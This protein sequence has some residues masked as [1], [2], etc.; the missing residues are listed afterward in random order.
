MSDDSEDEVNIMAPIVDV[1]SE[2]G[3]KLNTAR[4][5][6]TD[7]TYRSDSFDDDDDD[8]N[9]SI[10]QD[11]D[12]ASEDEKHE[13]SSTSRKTHRKKKIK[14]GRHVIDMTPP[15]KLLK[16][17]QKKAKHYATLK[18]NDKAL[19]ELIKCTALARIVYGD[20][21]WKYASAYYALAEGYLELKGYGPQ[22]KEHADTAKAIMM[23]GIATSSSESEKASIMELLMN[24]H[25]I[26]GRAL[27]MLQKYPEAEAALT[28]AEQVANKRSK[29]SCVKDSEIDDDDT[30]IF[31]A[32]ARLYAKQQKHASATE[33]FE[34]ALEIVKLKGD[35]CPELIPIY[36]SLGKVEQSKGKHA[37]HEHAIEMFLQA[38]SI[39]SANNKADSIATAET[40]RALASAY[41]KTGDAD[42][43]T[44]AESYLNECLVT[45][46]RVHGPYHQTTLDI[47]DDLARLMVRTGRQEEG[48]SLLRSTVEA[49]QEVFGEYSGEVADVYKLIGSVYLSEGNMEKALKAFKK[50]H[51]MQK[52]VYGEN[53]KK[54]KDTQKTLDVLLANPALSSKMGKS[55]ADELKDRPRFNGIVS[56][57]GTAGH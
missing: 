27:T 37:D 48:I 50:C 44:S 21:H 42:G 45:Y 35:D 6:I 14:K 28:K 7:S 2:K 31:M 9:E 29:L 36:Q 41:S 4:T 19:R 33:Y 12:I 57:T 10:E 13:K 56:R 52:T 53:H 54:T 22:S 23:S 8:D 18:K 3:G 38:H 46:Q 47:Q 15:D 34:R 11:E 51:T 24:I 25:F 5:D 1:S 16:K 26:L 39:S 55:K 49:K 17:C 20:G 30:K 43:E 32:V 40:A